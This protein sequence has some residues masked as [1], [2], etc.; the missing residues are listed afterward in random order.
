M[1]KKSVSKK[2]R[3][4]IDSKSKAGKASNDPKQEAISQDEPCRERIPGRIDDLAAQDALL[5]LDAVSNRF[6][7]EPNLQLAWVL[8]LDIINLPYLYILIINSWL[9]VMLHAS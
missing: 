2:R 6:N 9:H 8:L 1:P 3:K 7:P 4:S 5:Q